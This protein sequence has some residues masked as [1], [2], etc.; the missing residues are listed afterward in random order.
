M[1][2]WCLIKKNKNLKNSNELCIYI[3]NKVLHNEGRK[4]VNS[5][6]K[7]VYYQCSCLKNSQI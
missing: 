7:V 6:K 1:N 2:I 4:Y 3:S 5:F